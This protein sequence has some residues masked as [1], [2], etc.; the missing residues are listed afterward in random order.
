[1][2]RL[3]GAGIDRIDGAAR[4]IS[5]TQGVDVEFGGFE[6]AQTLGQGAQQVCKL[7]RLR[8]RLRHAHGLEPERRSRRRLRQPPEIGRY[9]GGDLRIAAG[10]VAIHHQHD[11]RAIAGHLNAA[12]DGAV[13]NDVVAMEMPDDGTFEAI[14]HAIAGRGNLP[15]AIEEQ[16]LGVVGKFIVLRTQHHT[17]T[18]R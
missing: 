6:A 18:V 12:V 5:T 1:M 16:R 13:G 11:R 14:A 8:L 7:S 10:G 15:I 17:D 3:P 4:D 2:F 9:H